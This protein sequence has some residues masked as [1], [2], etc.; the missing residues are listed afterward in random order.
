MKQR[1][2][3]LLLLLTKFFLANAQCTFEKFYN[4]YPG[5]SSVTKTISTSDG[6]FVTVTGATYDSL[7]PGNN[8]GQDDDICIVK[9]DAC[10]KL[11]WKTHFGDNVY[12]EKANDVIETESGDFLILFEERVI[13]FNSTG[14]FTWIKQYSSDFFPLSVIKR[15]NKDR[16]VISGGTSFSAFMFE[17]DGSGK[18]IR[19]AYPPIPNSFIEKLFETND[20]TYLLFVTSKDSLYLVN[21]DTLFNLRWKKNLFTRPD[22]MT[23]QSY[24]DAC[25]SYDKK[26]I[27]LINRVRITYPSFYWDYIIEQINFSGDLIRFKKFDTTN[28]ICT[29]I[30]ALSN[31]GY[32]QYG[33]YLQYMDSTLTTKKYV[34]TGYEKFFSVVENKDNSITA[35]GVSIRSNL[36]NELYIVRTDALGSIFHASTTAINHHNVE[37][38]IYP[39]PATT[40]LHIDANSIEKLYFQLYDISGK[41][42]SENIFF[43]NNT[44]ISLEELKQGLYFIQIRDSN[45]RLVHYQKLSVVK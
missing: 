15:E 14:Q 44:S 45:N 7:N 9:T 16:Y 13:K 20:S 3:F 21:T 30:S 28:R 32:V 35:S 8:N 43:T 6:G 4:F 25:L 1:T 26:C 23:Y 36:Y 27:T 37:C 38:N 5:V 12:L 31:N 24:L 39:N 29:G 33:Y 2:A 41:L 42:V 40:E 22:T 11:L 17:I 19:N 10:G 34:G 18:L